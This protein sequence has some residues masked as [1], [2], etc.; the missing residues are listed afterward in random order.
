[1]HAAG[2]SA[3]HRAGCPAP[4]THGLI[5]AGWA[6]RASSTSAQ[7]I[8]HRH[9]SRYSSA[10]VD[11]DKAVTVHRADVL[12]K[13]SRHAT[14]CGGVRRPIGHHRDASDLKFA[15]LADR[16]FLPLSSMT[17]SLWIGIKPAGGVGSGGASSP[18][19]PMPKVQALPCPNWS[20]Q[21]RRKGAGQPGDMRGGPLALMI[22]Y[23]AA[24]AARSRRPPP[25]QSDLRFGGHADKAC[26]LFVADD[27][28]RL[29]RV[30]FVHDGDLRA[31]GSPLKW[32]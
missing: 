12:S 26:H 13:A 23:S 19:M 29:L 31:H 24:R 2:A 30:P 10:M 20:R 3:T 1:M 7:D 28:D 32:I 14:P 27:L 25:Q 11:G 9:G 8:F 21:C 22:P 4:K 17:R 16:A 6:C 15:R 18:I 5:T